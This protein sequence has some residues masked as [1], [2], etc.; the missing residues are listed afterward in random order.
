MNRDILAQRQAGSAAGDEE[1]SAS[2][3]IQT[4]DWKWDSPHRMSLTLRPLTVV[5]VSNWK[6]EVQWLNLAVLIYWQM[7]LV[8][9]PNRF[10]SSAVDG[11]FKTW[12]RK[13]AAVWKSSVCGLIAIKWESNQ[14]ILE[15]YH[16]HNRRVWE[17]VR[18]VG[19][20]WYCARVSISSQG[21]GC[22]LFVLSILLNFDDD[23]KFVLC[24]LAEHTWHVVVVVRIW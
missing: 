5:V 7:C 3:T 16:P 12:K 21:G 20:N 13:C 15:I 17:D 9:L 22:C 23:Y 24:Y 2:S 19:S 11:Q 10:F 4:G 8:C 6:N 14:H 18:I 1:M